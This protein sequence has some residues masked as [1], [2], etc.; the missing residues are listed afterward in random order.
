MIKEFAFGLSNRHHF[1]EVSKMADWEGL[2]KDT[3]VSLYD[4]DEYVQEFIKTKGNLSGFDGLIYIPNEFV[5]DVDGKDF[6]EGKDKTTGLLIIVDA[7]ND[8]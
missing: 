6:K 5:L 2:D 7:I 4:Y 8:P 1:Q 3:F